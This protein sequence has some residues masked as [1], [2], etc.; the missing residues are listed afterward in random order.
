MLHGFTQSGIQFEQK[1]RSLKDELR[2]NILTNQA[3]KYHDIQFV[4]PNA[5]FPL[6]RDAL[7][8]FDLDGSR[9]QDGEIDAYTWWHL[10]R[11]GP[12]F[13]YNGLDVALRRIADT[14]REEG[15]F[16]GVVGFSQGAA[17]AMMVASLLE[18][19]RKDVFDRAET[20]SGMSYP[21]AFVSENAAIQP[22]LKFVVAMSGFGGTRVPEYQAF[23]HS[24]ITT[25]ALHIL[26]RADGFIKPAMGQEVIDAC[27][28][29]QVLYHSGG[30]AV[31]KADELESVTGL[32]K[33]LVQSLSL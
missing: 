22:P 10:N 16:D 21:T 8:S 29:P 27:A 25:P 30:H 23:Y 13:Y 7:P 12:P 28:N 5:P 14:I 6:E 31:P 20:A 19:G 26:G 4:F 1:T 18:S 2:R 33:F 9:Q 15:P 32:T 3:S 24:K 11:N 17:A